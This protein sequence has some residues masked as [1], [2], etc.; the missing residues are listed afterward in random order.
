MGPP[1]SRE[2]HLTFIS[3]FQD[4]DFLKQFSLLALWLLNT[5]EILFIEQKLSS[6][7][8]FKTRILTIDVP[9]RLN[10]SAWLDCRRLLGFWVRGVNHIYR[11]LSNAIILHLL[12]GIVL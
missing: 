9:I 5:L 12:L 2:L 3:Y 8:L 10:T 4:L 11:D 7:T 6:S 1:I